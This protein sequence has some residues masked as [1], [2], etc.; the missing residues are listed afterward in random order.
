VRDRLRVVG[1]VIV[2]SFLVLG[3]CAP[4]EGEGQ[5]SPEGQ[6]DDLSVYVVNYPLGYFAERIGGDDV[7]VV[8][9]VPA[10]EDPAFWAPNAEVV[11]AFQQ[12][13][14]ILLNGAGYAKWIARVTL[15]VSKLVDTSAGFQ[16]R[17]I[18]VDG[19]VTHSHGPEG[20]HSHGETAFTTWLDPTLA[21]EQARAIGR[22]MSRER[23]DHAVDFD[24]RTSAI[25]QDWSDL[26]AALTEVF[27]GRQDAPL[28][29]SHPVY[30]Y[31]ARRYSLNM[32]SVHFEPDE[33]PDEGA[34]ADLESTLAR[35]AA[36]WMLWEGEP[37]PEVRA[38]LR[39]MGVESV[40]FDPCG[41]RP[42]EGD[43]LS[44]MRANLENVRR[45]FGQE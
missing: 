16:D 38:R 19:R 2:F 8:L 20:D 33:F 10:G 29:G 11:E 32:E 34:W 44:V 24:E 30:Q 42:E 37:A 27:S 7:E 39:E 45:A 40:V 35:H 41:N 3:G 4:P 31:L 28:L 21:V 17:W 23:P 9:P 12:A 25:E 14:L 26:D 43:L 1:F 6:A 13:D 36:Q 22:A 18:L 15:P 5:P